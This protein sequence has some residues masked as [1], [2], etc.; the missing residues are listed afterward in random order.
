MGRDEIGTWYRAAMLFFSLVGGALVSLWVNSIEGQSPA[1]A[2]SS[3][4]SSANAPQ[5][6]GPAAGLVD[7]AAGAI[8]IDVDK[9]RLEYNRML[10]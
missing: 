1:S 10:N 8:G 6:I 3:N 5:T 2:A 4:Q 9:H 7:S